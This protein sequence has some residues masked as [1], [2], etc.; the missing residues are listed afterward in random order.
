MKNENPIKNSLI[1]RNSYFASKKINM[2]ENEKEIENNKEIISRSQRVNSNHFVYCSK[3]SNV[4]NTSIN[5]EKENDIF[6]R[7]ND[8]INEEGLDHPNPLISDNE[9]NLEE[10]KSQFITKRDDLKRK[11]SKDIKNLTDIDIILNITS[12]RGTEPNELPAETVKSNRIEENNT[13]IK[14]KILYKKNEK[15]LALNKISKIRPKTHKILK[16]HK[17]IN[18][19]LNNKMNISYN[20][21]NNDNNNN[22]KENEIKMNKYIFLSKQEN[23]KS[24]HEIKIER[25]EFKHIL[26]Y[27]DKK[28]KQNFHYFNE[29]NR[30][31]PVI[32]SYNYLNY[33]DENRREKMNRFNTINNKLNNKLN[34][35]STL[36]QVYKACEKKN[37][38]NNSINNIKEGLLKN[39]SNNPIYNQTNSDEK[40]NLNNNILR[41]NQ[42]QQLLNRIKT[43]YPNKRKIIQNE[44]E[45]EK[46]ISKILWTE[47]DINTK[48]YLN[49]QYNMIKN[50]CR[51]SNQIIIDSKD[52]STNNESQT[53]GIDKEK[54]LRTLN[55]Y[56]SSKNKNILN[57]MLNKSNN[58]PIFNSN[59]LK[60]PTLKKKHVIF[61]KQK[62]GNENIPKNRLKSFEKDGNF[63][64]IQTTFIVIS[65][66]TKRKS[67]QKSKLTSETQDLSKYRVPIPSI[68]YKNYSKCLKRKIN[69]YSEYTFDIKDRRNIG[70]GHKDFAITNSVNNISMKHNNYKNELSSEKNIHHYHSNNKNY[71]DC[72]TIT[73][74]TRILY[75]YRNRRISDLINKSK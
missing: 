13:P 54:K 42:N 47:T 16:N 7:T 53:I 55:R 10:L 75:S 64:N 28:E 56:K 18:K 6:N 8:L 44:Y 67:L 9:E 41:N 52:L 33:G 51:N 45:N 29:Y 74:N 11:R 12:G 27:M 31:K 65:K 22:K 72:P 50:K 26:N 46:T 58:I 39:K 4:R 19:S 71:F 30:R 35:L 23:N 60:T 32:N 49:N 61:S 66:N 2:K 69:L 48:S 3:Y 20:N 17:Q 37:T 1:Y 73:G 62:N 15:D 70:N 24:S 43:E 25:E 14:F 68:S 59:E 5:K 40:E 63:N 36:K 38:Q 57:N 21:T 34:K